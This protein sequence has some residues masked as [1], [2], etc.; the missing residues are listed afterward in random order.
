M[1]VLS[2]HRTSHYA[3]ETA[4][5]VKL[6]IEIL[7]LLRY[8]SFI[9]NLIHVD[10]LIHQLEDLCLLINSKSCQMFKEYLHILAPLRLP[11]H[12]YFY[13]YK[14]SAIHDLPLSQSVNFDS[15]IILKFKF[16]K[17]KS[18]CKIKLLKYKLLLSRY[19]SESY[20]YVQ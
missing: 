9:F 1:P 18:T 3:V 17:T 6:Q 14:K 12:I 2:I 15:T 11:M 5:S 10:I 8:V 19:L 20:L 13:I 4:N 16:L 7:S